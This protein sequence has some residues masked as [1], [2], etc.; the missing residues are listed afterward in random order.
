MD[1]SLA[2]GYF[3][4]FIS[5]LVGSMPDSDASSLIQSFFIGDYVSGAIL[6]FGFFFLVCFIYF[7]FDF[8]KSLD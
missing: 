5:A 8:D 1:I 7:N 3:P 6:N 2:L 4:N